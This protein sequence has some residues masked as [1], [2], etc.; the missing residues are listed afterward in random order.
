MAFLLP[1][2]SVFPIFLDLTHPSTVLP[3]HI[4]RLVGGRG[5]SF[6]VATGLRGVSGDAFRNAS[7]IVDTIPLIL[8]CRTGHAGCD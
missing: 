1:C 5:H 8:I 7:G 2:K 4:P 6:Q 3:L